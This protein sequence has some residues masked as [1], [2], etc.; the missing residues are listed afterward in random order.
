MIVRRLKDMIIANLIAYIILLIGGLNWGL[1][2]IFN[3]N[4]VGAIMGGPLAVG[5]V[6]IYI[7]VFISA[8]WLIISPFITRGILKLSERER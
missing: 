3:W 8:I 1:V 2:G 7:L 6:I 5:A 4:L